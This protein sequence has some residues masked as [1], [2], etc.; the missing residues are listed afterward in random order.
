MK[1]HIYSAMIIAAAAIGSTAQ[2]QQTVTLKK[3][4]VK[5]E[6]VKL[7]DGDYLAFGRPEGCLLYTSPSPRD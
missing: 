3:G 4:D 1:R 2:A 5:V 6:T 7:A